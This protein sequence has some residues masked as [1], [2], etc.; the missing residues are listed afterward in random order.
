[1]KKT[2][3]DM[4]SRVAAA[5]VK[6][7]GYFSSYENELTQ[8]VFMKG[9]RLLTAAHCLKYN[10]SGMFNLDDLD[11][12]L[13]DIE[14]ATG[15]TLKVRAVVIEPVTDIAVLGEPDDED[16]FKE[17]AKFRS[18]YGTIQPLT[19]AKPPSKFP[20]QFSIHIL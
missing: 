1:M 17:W 5:T 6:L 2:L 12:M 10:S 11:S 16:F 19:L 3:K 18:V 8:A 20:A 15:K 7:D 9:G 14:T 13:Y 4:Y